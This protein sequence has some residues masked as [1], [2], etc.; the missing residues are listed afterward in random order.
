MQYS[1]CHPWRKHTSPPNDPLSV[2]GAALSSFGGGSA[3]S[4]GAAALSGIGT[5][6]SAASTL[7]GGGY[8]AQAGQ[9]KEAEANFE[10]EQDIE[11]AAGET[12]A[13][14][15]QAIDTSQKANL[16]R[17]SA[18]ANAAAGGVNA[19]AGSALTNQAQIAARGSYQA[20][21]ELWSGQNRATG[22]LNQAA[23]TRY[24][25]YM[26]ALGGQEAQQASELNAMSTIAGG[27]ASML[28]MYGS[29]G[30]S[31]TGRMSS[32]DFG[33]GGTSYPMFS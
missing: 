2:T 26:A 6:F 15:R 9:M 22:L 27:G 10:A 25:G 23:G 7:A 3:I 18:V 13:A 24:T 29:T 20:G 11:N 31:A 1:P 30:L 32:T 21:M 4:G 33:T 12:A 8:A 5:A 28:R 14:Q 17:S 16:L 19:G